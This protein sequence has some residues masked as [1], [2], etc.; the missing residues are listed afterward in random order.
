VCSG[1][2]DQRGKERRKKQKKLEKKGEGRRKK[3]NT[4][5]TL[6]PKLNESPKKE[7]INSKRTTEEF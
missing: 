3:R 2:P 5:F 6:L 7:E 4:F 1:I